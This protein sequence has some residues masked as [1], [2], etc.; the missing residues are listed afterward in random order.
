MSLSIGELAE[1]AQVYVPRAIARLREYGARDR[2]P[3]SVV[4]RPCIARQIANLGGLEL[5]ILP[6]GYL[7]SPSV[8][9]LYRGATCCASINLS[10]GAA[11]FHYRRGQPAA[12][13]RL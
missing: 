7:E 8:L 1:N 10:T 13:W 12:S 4:A 9:F 6:A 11:T 5:R 3:D 2:Q